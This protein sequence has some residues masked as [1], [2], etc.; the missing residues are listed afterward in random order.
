M[1]LELPLKIDFSVFENNYF[2]TLQL[3]KP[4]DYPN[5]YNNMACN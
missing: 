2:M 3:T 4:F 1:R 5:L